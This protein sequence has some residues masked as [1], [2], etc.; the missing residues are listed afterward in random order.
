MT[1]ASPEKVIARALAYWVPME[2]PWITTSIM[3][4]LAASGCVIAP[5]VATGAMIEAG[6]ASEFAD[7]SM[8][9]AVVYAAMIA[10]SQEGKK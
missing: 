1:D 5:K 8:S 4:A 9:C 10:A 3:D 6:R 7:A 2:A